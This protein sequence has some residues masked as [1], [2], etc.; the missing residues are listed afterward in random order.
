MCLSI[1]PIQPCRGAAKKK[2]RLIV[3]V[4]RL[5]MRSAFPMLTGSLTLL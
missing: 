2:C 4:V 3:A 5:F 1:A